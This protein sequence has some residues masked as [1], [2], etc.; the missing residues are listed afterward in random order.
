MLKALMLSVAVAALAGCATS[1]PMDDQAN[2]AVI[3][4]KIEAKLAADPQTESYE[5]DTDTQNG[6]V[7]LRGFVENEAERSQ[8]ERLA[9]NTQGVRSVDNQLKLGDLSAEQNVSDTWIVT[10]VKSQLAADPEVNSFNIDVDS[11]NGQVTLSGIVPQAQ[12]R[13]EAE[14]IAK[15]TQG[16]KMVRN[17]IRVR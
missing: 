15:A 17:E 2:D 8:A 14:R 6:R 4:S 3:T 13:A 5:I 1:R 12:A 11:L 7:V 9:K 10:K 16:V